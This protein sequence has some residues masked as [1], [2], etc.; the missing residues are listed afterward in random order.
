MKLPSITNATLTKVE[1]AGFT[2]DYNEVATI[3]AT[4]WTGTE[5]VFWSEITE[6][7][8][9]GDGGRRGRDQQQRVADILVRRFLVVDAALAVT[10]AIGDIVSVTF[11][12]I[13]ETGVVDR[14]TITKATGLAGV[15]RL[16]LRNA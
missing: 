10:F 4:K 9:T 7:V 12:S 5:E 15:V 16:E 3:G 13:A 8:N 2:S 6:H 11:N 14:V 1:T